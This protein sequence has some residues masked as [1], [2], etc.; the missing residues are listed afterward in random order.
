MKRKRLDGILKNRVALPKELIDN[1]VKSMP[2]QCTYFGNM[3]VDESGLI[4]VPVVDVANDTGQEYDIF[5]DTGKYLYHAFMK[6]PNGLIIVGYPVLKGNHLYLFV[7][8]GEGERK[9]VK[10]KTVK[11][12]L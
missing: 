2:D 1:M 6:L 5:S 7:E 9:L 12:G 11:P 4:Y 8:D 10:Y 3:H